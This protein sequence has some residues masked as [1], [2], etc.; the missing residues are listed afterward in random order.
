MAGAESLSNP[1]GGNEVGASGGARKDSLGLSGATRHGERVCLGHGDDLV[2]VL[3]PQQRW[4]RP[5]AAPL[6][7]V[8]ASQ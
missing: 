7:V 4:P 6:D 1:N 2:E 3:R 5:D 8:G